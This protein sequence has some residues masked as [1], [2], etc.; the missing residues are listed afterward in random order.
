[1]RTK[2]FGSFSFFLLYVRSI[3]YGNVAQNVLH[4][5][6]NIFVSV[7]INAVEFVVGG[8]R[9]IAKFVVKLLKSVVN[10]FATGRNLCGQQFINVT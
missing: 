3:Y 2:F 5:V 7:W 4:L 8:S 10:G 6:A 1:M 9:I